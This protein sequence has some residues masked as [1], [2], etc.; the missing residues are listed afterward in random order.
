M[1]LVM[2]VLGVK[3]FTASTG[4]GRGWRLYTMLTL[5]SRTAARSR[6]SARK[7]DLDLGAQH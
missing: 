2:M 1:R 4:M 3:A 7:T 6:K 5:A